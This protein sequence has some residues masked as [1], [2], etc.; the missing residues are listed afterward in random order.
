M[1]YLIPVAI[2]D[3][4]IAKI[5]IRSILNQDCDSKIVVVTSAKL[6]DYFSRPRVIAI[7]ED[8]IIKNLSFKVVED[9]I[10]RLSSQSTRTGW[11]FQQF[12]K[13]A[14][15]LIAEKNYVIWDSD[16]VMLKKVVFLEDDK[17][18]LYFNDVDEHLP[19]LVT[20]KKLFPDIKEINDVSFVT[21]K[22]FVDYKIMQ[23]II[24]SIESKF[25]K[26]FFE[27]IL[28]NIEE[29]N[30]LG[31]GFS[32]FATYAHYVINYY[33]NNYHLEK[34]SHFRSGTRI[35]GELPDLNDLES[36]ATYY[37]SISFEKWQK[38]IIVNRKTS[39]FLL[40]LMGFKIYSKFIFLLTAFISKIK[41]F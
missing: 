34:S 28:E 7:D 33:S 8:K 11:Y 23:E 5:A 19:Y 22:M 2:K 18:I 31:S 17:H 25:A 15:A 10:I 30:L 38:K 29:S 6:I 32:E 40:T 4:E 27:A 26:S 36:V 21:E 20:L 14:Y 24:H 39:K 41:T 35:F 12:I 37:N 9:I 1:D 16:T 13:M 3:K